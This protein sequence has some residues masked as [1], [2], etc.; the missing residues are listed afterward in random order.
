MVMKASSAIQTV[1]SSATASKPKPA[2][3][4][5]R[6]LVV[7]RVSEDDT[8]ALSSVVGGE[9]LK[10]AVVHGTLIAC[11]T[12]AAA[13]VLD[14][15]GRAAA[16]APSCRTLATDLTAK[17]TAPGGFTADIKTSC[18]FNADHTQATCTVQYNDGRGTE[19]S[20]TST[21]TYK[22]LADIIDEIVVNPPLNYA[23]MTTAA[24]AVAGGSFKGTVTN[25]FDANRR[26]VKT[27]NI[28]VSGESTT[29]YSDWDQA[30]RPTRANDVGKGF[31]NVRVISYDDAART[32][33]TVV[34]G[35]P[36]RTVETFDVNGN[37]IETL[38]TAGGTAMQTKTTVTI[39]ASHR[40]CK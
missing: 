5:S 24:T 32:R 28:G 37:Q 35:G 20:T 26:I 36:L 33:T 16:G 25:T 2:M 30:G 8:A 19:S 15:Q 22:S 4:I 34:N 7:G 21:T 40:A 38:A 6:E 9:M 10:S 39:T 3:R 11:V 31:N 1:R 13:A 18:T 12:A 27:V 29:T 23:Q 14:G 17:V